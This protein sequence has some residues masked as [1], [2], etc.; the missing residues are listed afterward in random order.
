MSAIFLRMS[1]FYLF[2]KLRSCCFCDTSQPTSSQGDLSDSCWEIRHEG[3]R[4][5]LRLAIC[6]DCN[7]CWEDRHKL[8]PPTARW[9]TNSQPLYQETAQAGAPPTSTPSRW[10]SLFPAFLGVLAIFCQLKLVRAFPISW[11]SSHYCK[12]RPRLVQERTRGR[13]WRDSGFLI[14]FFSKF[15]FT[16]QP[17]FSSAPFPIVASKIKTWGK[18]KRSNGMGLTP[19][20]QKYSRKKMQ[21]PRLQS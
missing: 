19:L 18:E 7:P 10:L 9:R 8:T 3:V 11:A 16:F 6:P 13:Q 20:D 1:S 2:F 12:T 15:H 5:V 17:Q 21:G 4:D 14:F